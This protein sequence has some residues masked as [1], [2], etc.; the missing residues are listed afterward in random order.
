LDIPDG[1]F[2]I[3]YGPSGS[4]KTNL[5]DTLIGLNTPT[6]GKVFYEGKDLYTMKANE[7]A[8]FRAHTMGVVRQS[9]NW[10]R[11]LNVLEN[12]AL[13]LHFLGLRP[14]AAREA[15]MR[16]LKFVGIEQYA[17]HMP[18]VL[19]GGEQQ[20]VAMARTLVNNPSYIVADEP[21]G[22]LDSKNGDKLIELLR[23]MNKDLRRTVVLVTHNLEYLSVADQ[24]LLIED[25]VVT[26]MR[27]VEMSKATDDILRDMRR[28]IGEWAR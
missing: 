9:S 22:N 8:F 20:R 3:I 14:E 17:K 27:G 21:T 6:S 15:A 7:R 4:G 1:S 13:P 18:S 16:S 25:G 2:T 19:S 12:V 10:V 5:L 23:Y 28:R 24:L 11:S 26:S